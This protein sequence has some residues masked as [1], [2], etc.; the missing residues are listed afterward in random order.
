MTRNTNIHPR[1]FSRLNRLEKALNVI[2]GVT[3]LVT[4][5]WIIHVYIAALLGGK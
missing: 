1:P 4:L 3:G 5:G 2:L